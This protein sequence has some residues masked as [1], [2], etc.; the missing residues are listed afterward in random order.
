MDSAVD[1][2]DALCV[3]FKNIQKRIDSTLQLVGRT[4]EEVTLVAISKT[5]PAGRIA[6]ALRCG[7]SNVGENRVQEAEPKIHELGRTSARWHLVGH[8][9]A[10][11]ARKAVK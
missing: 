6:A 4:A 3:R 7:V 5:H 11:K 2:D 1:L 8:L 10:N 9:Q